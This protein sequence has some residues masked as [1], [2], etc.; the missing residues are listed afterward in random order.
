[1]L[2]KNGKRVRKGIWKSQKQTYAIQQKAMHVVHNKKRWDIRGKK[3]ELKNPTGM[4]NN[5]PENHYLNIFAGTS[6]TKSK[7]KTS[8]YVEM[9]NL[10]QLS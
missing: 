9:F 4:K 2:G 5:W 3:G 7:E 10:S 1:M 6:R 8:S